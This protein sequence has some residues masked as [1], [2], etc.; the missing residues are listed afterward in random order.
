MCLTG[1]LYWA[2]SIYDNKRRDKLYGIP[3][4]AQVE[5][6]DEIFHSGETDG[7]NKQFR[8]SY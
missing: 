6:L 1:G 8:Y 3:S 7:V 4:M 2:L 5:L